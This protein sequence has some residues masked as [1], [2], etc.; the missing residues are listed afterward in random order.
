[1]LYLISVLMLCFSLGLAGLAS[2]PSPYYGALT[3]VSVSG[4]GCGLLVLHGGN[5]LA[6]LL[7]L[8]YLGGML[9]V[10]AFT[11]A[12]ASDLHPE[13]FTSPGTFILISLYFVGLC[14][15]AFIVGTGGWYDNC[16][17]PEEIMNNT[18]D[19]EVDIAGITIVFWRLDTF[20]VATAYMLLIALLAVLE[21][22]RGLA[23]GAMRMP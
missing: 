5:Y 12:L 16:C 3:M 18:P 4:V 13:T 14:V 9:V 7:F 20:L 6:F 22:T 2:N 15:L 11:A 21:L 17:M 8:I 1:M 23:R 19:C 10:F